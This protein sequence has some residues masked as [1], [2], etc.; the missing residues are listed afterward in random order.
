M[1]SCSLRHRFRNTRDIAANAME[2]EVVREQEGGM[3]AREVLA[4]LRRHKGQILLVSAVLAAISVV[5]AIALPAK[6]RSTATIL[7]QEQEVPPDLV[8]STI[9]SFA[10]ERIQVISHQIMTRARL[11]ELVDKFDLYNHVRERLN[12]DEILERIRRDIKVSNINADISDR[13]SG[14]RVNATIAFTISYDA[15][16]PDQAQMVVKELT[17]LYLDE[18]LKARQQSVA[19]TQEFLAQEADRLGKQIQLTEKRLADFKRRN[20]GRMPDASTVYVQLADR[21]ESELRRV[22]QQISVV[23]DRKMSLEAQLALI[24]PNTPRSTVS[25]A[26][27]DAQ[28]VS[29]SEDRLR[30]LQAQ[31]ARLSTIYGADHPD[32]RRTRR[33]IAALKSQTT[34]SKAGDP[35]RAA[36]ASTVDKSHAIEANADNPAY[37][38]LAAQLESSKRE[39]K[40]LTAM[41]DDLRAKQRT[42]DARLMQIPDVEREYNDLTRD[43]SNAQARYREIKTKQLQAEGAVELEKD[44]KAER[45]SLGEPANFPQRPFSPNRMAIVLGGFVASLGSGLGLA[46]LREMIDPSVKGPLQ[47]GRLASVPL[48]TPIPYIETRSERIRIR[49]RSWSTA[50]VV[51]ILGIAFLVAIHA[52]L[53]PLPEVFG[54]VMRRI[55]TL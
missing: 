45:F 37:V 51:V 25:A 43:Y 18:N 17:S 35:E 30:T 44:S 21:T 54:A 10:D 27:S 46:L 55:A 49:A 20:V 15:R 13:S 42:Y 5:V 22:E 31:E 19:E 29:S 32:V 53:K 16:R 52:L 14:R 26:V 4:M 39:L 7:V 34:A 40:Q 36:V 38:V 11:L 48:L 50:G 1:L 47:L 6:Y 9:T 12:D 8:R 23:E 41:R 2:D 24:K 33:E 3:Q 28:H